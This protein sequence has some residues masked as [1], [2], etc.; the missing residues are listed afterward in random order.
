MLNFGTSLLFKADQKN[1]YVS[2]IMLS[3]IGITIG[4]YTVFEAL[5]EVRARY[6]F[7]YVPFYCMVAA[8]GADAVWK[9]VNT[10]INK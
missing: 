9:K 5:F 3:L 8:M 7:I 10:V 1:K 4:R 6:L 2:V